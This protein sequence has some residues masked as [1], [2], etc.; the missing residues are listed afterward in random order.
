[1]AGT[2]ALIA[3][4]RT[5]KP[6]SVIKDQWQVSFSRFIIYPSVPSTC[7][8]L[9][10]RL[11]KRRCCASRGTWISSRSPTASLQLLNYHALS[12]AILSVCF[13]DKMLEEHYVSKLH[14]TWPHVSCVSGYPP[15]GSRAVFVS[16]KDSAGEIQKFALRFSVIS[17]AERFINALKDILKEIS[18]T[19]LLNSGSPT[20]ISSPSVF[21][22][23][24]ETPSRACEEQSS[25][26]TTGQAYSPQLS[27]DYEV[28][29]ESYIEKTQLNHISEGIS[30]ALP[31]SF[32][33]FLTNCCSEVK[34]DARRPSSSE[35]IDLK[36]QI[37]RY[38]EDSSFQG[39]HKLSVS[40]T[41]TPYTCQ[42][43]GGGKIQDGEN[44]N[45]PVQSLM[46]LQKRMLA[47]DQ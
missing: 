45:V 34:Q 8:F 7:P 18:E 40:E 4:E 31:P 32:A 1:M 10:H 35:N 41:K 16:Y 47:R 17:E 28:E 5:E 44:N 23:T 3:S 38:M 13:S 42:A 33:S 43:E 15:R 9:V 46:T 30:C 25:V 26:M 27:F 39:S 36:S 6:I 11:N 24:N 37:A 20:E 21:L 2:L 22:S 12:D 19:E 29:K 14:F